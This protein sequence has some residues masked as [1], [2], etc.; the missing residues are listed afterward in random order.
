M[1]TVII[2]SVQRLA[3]CFY[4]HVKLRVGNVASDFKYFEIILVN[5]L[6]Q[7]VLMFR[8]NIFKLNS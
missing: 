7:P 5:T 1:Y 6:H 4:F 3:A 8:N 2:I